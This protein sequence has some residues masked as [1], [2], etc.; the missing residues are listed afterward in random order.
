MVLKSDRCLVSLKRS[1]TCFYEDGYKEGFSNLTTTVTL[2]TEPSLK[3]L[4]CLKWILWT[5]KKFHLDK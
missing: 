1:V 2:K 3:V 5:F 4:K